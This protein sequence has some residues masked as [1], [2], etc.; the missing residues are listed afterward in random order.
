[1]NGKKVLFKQYLFPYYDPFSSLVTWT[2]KRITP[3]SGNKIIDASY[4][5]DSSKT[6]NKTGFFVGS[7]K[8]YLLTGISHFY[9]TINHYNQ[10]PEFFGLTHHDIGKKR[11]VKDIEIRLNEHLISDKDRS[12]MKYRL[13]KNDHSNFS[14]TI[15]KNALDKLFPTIRAAS[16]WMYSKSLK[17]TDSNYK[18]NAN[19]DLIILPETQVDS[20][21]SDGHYEESSRYAMLCDRPFCTFDILLTYLIYDQKTN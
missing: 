6:E 17:L 4:T 19:E 1:M 12:F 9:A 5:I 7:Y 14:K 21:N 16:D 20:L 15:M 2:T 13:L 10:S 3:I 18:L 11:F 8:W